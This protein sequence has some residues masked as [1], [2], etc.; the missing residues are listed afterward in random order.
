[1][2]ESLQPTS[3][4]SD[5][6]MAEPISSAAPALSAEAL[7][8]I[9]RRTLQHYAQNVVS[10]WEGTRHHDVSQNYDAFLSALGDGGPFTLLDFGCGPGRDLRYFRS[11]GHEAVGLDGCEQFVALARAY[12]D[13]EVL[14]QDFL[15]LS[16]PEG[17]FDGIFAN[18]TLFHVPRQELSRV[19]GCLRRSLKPEGVLFCSNPRG[20][21]EEHWSGE[22]YG[23]FHTWE[24]WRGIVE[25]VGFEALH[26]YY[27]PPGLPRAQQPWLASVWRK[28]PA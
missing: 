2:P 15:N 13:C 24:R 28:R 17:R 11:L 26:H 20:A 5:A 14:H 19:L 27:R 18:A 16:L 10:F 6:A 4:A 8:E 1:M 12:A 23:S 3:A 25:A 22:R 21:D 9:S 7:E